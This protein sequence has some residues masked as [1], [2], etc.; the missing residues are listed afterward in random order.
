MAGTKDIL[1]IIQ[2][3]ANGA[4]EAGVPANVSYGKVLS[5][6]PLTVKTREGFT[7]PAA[8]L[9]LCRNVTD[10]ETEVTITTGY[11]W[12]TQTRSGGAGDAAF[13]SH[14]HDIVIDRKKIKIHNAL[15]VGDN[16]AMVKAKGGQSYLIIDRVVV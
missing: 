7:V 9:E 1:K 13:A 10:F 16:V 12:E 11:G 2:Q 15:K 6:D 3:A 14:A 5:I 8:A 4:N